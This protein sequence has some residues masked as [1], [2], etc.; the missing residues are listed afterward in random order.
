MKLWKIK[1]ENP[2]RDSIKFTF[3]FI[4][5]FILCIVQTACVGTIKDANSQKSLGNDKTDGVSFTYTGILNAKAIANDKVEIFFPQAE[6]DPDDLAYVVRYDG[7]QIPL[8]IYGSSLRPDY[9]GQLRTTVKNL[10]VNSTYVFSVQVR[11]VK[12]GSESNNSITKIVKT[13]SN[14][15]ANFDGVVE[16]R[17]LPGAAGANGIQVLW[18]P[19][20]FKGTVITKD[21]IDPIEYRVTV[22]DG[23]LLS[24]N[25]MNDSNFEEPERKIVSASGDKRSIIVNGLIP[26]RK[27][28]V[29]VRAVHYGYSQFSAD[30][31]YK[32]EENTNYIEISTY[33]DDIANL[34]FNDAS[35]N[36]TY[37]QGAG[38]LYSLKANWSAPNGNFDHYRIYYTVNGSSNLSTYLNAD[39]VDMFCSGSETRD[40]NVFCKEV[41]YSNINELITGLLP[42]TEYDLVLAICTSTNCTIDKRK[43]SPVITTKTAPPVAIFNGISSI[44]PAKNIT[45]LDRLFLNIE[46]PNFL[47]GNI[48]GYLIKY[49]GSDPSSLSPLILNDPLNGSGLGYVPYDVRTATAIEITGVDPTSISNY[50]FKL[51]PY[52]ANFD[53]SITEGNDDSLSVVCTL[54]SIKGPTLNEFSGVLSYTC[55]SSAKQIQVL[56]NKPS[57]GIYSH[58]Q[59]FYQNTLGDFNFGSAT[60]PSNLH[61]S[62]VLVPGDQTST[63]LTSLQAGTT[64][65]VGVLTYYLSGNGPVRSEFNTTFF[66][67]SL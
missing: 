7:Q 24:P 45:E 41:H 60:D 62:S 61:Y 52:V 10:D 13:F 32:L 11:N 53:G 54:P 21:E 35:F 50:C 18:N 56:W 66:S 9:K 43:T 39:P 36:I 51:V 6:G 4:Y 25:S 48:S 58:I 23:S 34:E 65:R 16:L 57:S 31:N 33:S 44:S 47:S 55:N 3:T 46:L 12:T 17:H 26:D 63:T 20:E 64:Y 38:G 67:C 8:Y 49:Y 1:N 14:L 27:Y 28:Y 5:L 15:T 42:Y 30:P 22:I 2:V 37:P 29:Q 59:V 40:S 19:A